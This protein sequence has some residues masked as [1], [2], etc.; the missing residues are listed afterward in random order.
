MIKPF[1]FFPSK[2][3]I[4]AIEMLLLVFGKKNPQDLFRYLLTSAYQTENDKRLKYG[5]ERN[6]R[7]AK[8]DDQNIKISM[9]ESMTDEELTNHLIEIGY[10][11]APALCNSSTGSWQ[12]NLIKTTP[13][14]RFWQI[15]NKNPKTGKVS[16][17]ADVMTWVELINDLKKKKLI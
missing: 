17:Q 14:G 9:I 7:M 15:I 16:Y 12:Y 13:R 6:L 11:P 5:Y 10:F 2:T 4:E 8:K 1:K 3:E